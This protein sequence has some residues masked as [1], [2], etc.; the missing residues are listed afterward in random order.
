MIGSIIGAIIGG[1]I[2]GVLARLVLPGKQNI[3]MLM[4]IGIGIVSSFVA[5]LIVGAIGYRNAHGIAWIPLIVGVIVAAVLIT[6]YCN[7]AG[8]KSIAR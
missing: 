7:H 4:T 5:S 2:I 3:S 1:L 6:L 8:R